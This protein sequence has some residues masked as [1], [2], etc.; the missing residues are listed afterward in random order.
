[1]K[2]LIILQ[3]PPASGK[4]TWAK[5]FV[6]EIGSKRDHP[7]YIVVSRDVIRHSF[8]EYNMKH[9][10]EV[11][12]IEYSSMLVNMQNG[13]NII[14]NDATN[15]N[16]K[17]LKQ[18][19]DL[20]KQ[21]EYE[22]EYKTFYVPFEEAVKRDNN[23]DREHHVGKAVIKKFYKAY[24]PEQYEE[25][26]K[27]T[28]DHKRIDIDYN[29][30]KAIMCDIDGTTAWMQH[31]SPYNYKEVSNDKADFR[32]FQLLNLLRKSS[33]KIIFVSG[34]E[35]SDQCRKD[36]YNWIQKNL[37]SDCFSL[38]MRKE[39]DFRPDEIIKKEIYENNIK[40]IFDVVAVFD[41]RNKVV[42][43]WRD[44][45]MLCCQVNDGDF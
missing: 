24:Y 20:A 26:C 38:L 13:T 1:M 23:A 19:E 30:P 4:S 17:Y 28:V 43:M 36:T 41:D 44:L 12:K 7:T 8:G 27:Q 35:G 37:E 39:H 2:K 42:N 45:G 21:Y 3:G 29:L 5:K 15:L 11:T 6:V 40:D 22:I 34:R 25:E 18:W 10:K 33:V 14:I 31:R 16:P 32:M 9:E